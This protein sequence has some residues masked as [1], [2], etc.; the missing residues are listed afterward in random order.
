MG[1]F[2]RIWA[3]RKRSE[4][5]REIE[6]EL[7]DHLQMRTNANI[8]KGMS[9][10]Q[11]ARA[12]RLKF[13]NPE[14]FKERVEAEDAA[15][16]LE[17]LIRDV[18]HAVRGFTNSPGF[19]AVAIITLALG[20]GANTAIFQLLDAVR[21]RSLPIQKPQELVELRIIGG[22]HG[23]GVNNEQYDYFTIPMWLEVR[24]HHDPLSGVFAW[25]QDE[26]MVGT[27]TDGKRVRALEV[28]GEFFKV[29]GVLPWQGRLIEPQD[30]ADCNVWKVVASYTF[31]KA[32]MGGEPITPNTTILVEGHTVQVLGVTPP[33][34]FG[35]AVGDR[36]DLAYPSCIP[37]NPRREE[38]NMSVMGRLK[39]GWDIARASG[40]FTSI[41]PGLFEST[42]PTGYD[43]ADVKLFKSFKL[44][45]Y[46][47]AAGVS[48]LRNAYDSSLQLLLAITGLV[49]LIACA[50]LANLMLARANA[51]Q[52]ELAIRMA[53][54]ASRHRMLRQLLI[55]SGLLALSGA[56]LGVALAQPL[57]RLLVAALGTSRYSIHLA[58]VTDWRVLLFAAVVATLTCLVFGT[59]PAMRGANADPI[60][61]LKSG[62]R[63]I[64]G[65]RRHFFAQRLMV[66]T[67]VAVSLV[68]LVGA[69]LFV[70]SY[71]NLL[72]LDPGMRK[73]GIVSGYFDFPTL[74]I[75]PQEEAEFKRRLVE[76]V[77]SI[78]GIQNAASTTN[79]P[80][81]GSTWGHT[82]HVG[83]TEG[84]SRFT[85][86]SPSYFATMGIPLLTGRGFTDAD[87][88]D[89]PLVLIVNQAFIRKYFGL[90]Q[91]I[92]KLV[93]VMPEPHYP[94][95]TYQIIGTIPDTRYSDLREE[96]PPIAFVPAAQLP[97]EAQGPGMAM[98]IASDTGLDAI[99]TIRRTLEAKYPAMQF[100]NFIVFQQQISDQLVG[101]RLMAML[102]GFFGLLAALL[103]LIGV[104]G[105]LSYFITQRRNEIGI[106]IALGAKRRQVIAL[107]IRDTAA[108]LLTGII[109]GTALALLAGRAA[110]AMLFGLKPYDLVTLV[111]AIAL[112]AVIGILASLL[113]A[114][115]ASN[116]DPVTALRTE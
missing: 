39:P 3:L 1:I 47:A 55:E 59:I 111:F 14:A 69:L 34:F 78:P 82:V 10:E 97:V 38:F 24:R 101:E 46:P 23:L 113:P 80:L 107:V 6:A 85:Y 68:L 20:I 48:T 26:A 93:H 106:R 52:R 65:N 63:G 56:T 114:V 86:A 18:R 64:V 51:R 79:V 87:T 8:A 109:L 70:R 44:G 71:R 100:F 7:R 17:S 104:Y 81:S 98:M 27:S 40:Y 57:S 108:M 36:F 89:A 95:R 33:S 21:L 116:L 58:I 94:E 15:L 54:G 29:L 74:N 42:A 28:S 49:L 30:E 43:A 5:D 22:N 99:T 84:E 31:W 67:Q 9:P 91:P 60:A 90:A 41:S 12:A 92:G 35:V 88:N 25:R 112:L 16:S 45:A 105:L 83:A 73:S 103:V 50:N 72:T 11:A 19:T 75:K 110:T 13:G 32:Q 66:I 4:L 2:R 115:K 77:R 61:A 62:E 102:S 53:L 76:D 37:P 96:P